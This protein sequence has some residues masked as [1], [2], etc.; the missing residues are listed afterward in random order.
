MKLAGYRRELVEIERVGIAV[1]VPTDHV[2]GMVLHDVDRIA[3]AVGH[4]HFELAAIRSWFPQDGSAKVALV[5]RRMFFELT[6]LVTK[7]ARYLDHARRCIDEHTRILRRQNAVRRSGRNDDVVVRTVGQRAERC[8]QYSFAL[9][10][11][12]KLVAAGIAVE[13]L[14]RPIDARDRHQEVAISKERHARFY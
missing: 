1:A 14:H 3:I 6:E 10:N 12:K 5:V 8:L 9:V 7:L 2:A 13:V 11:K 4:A